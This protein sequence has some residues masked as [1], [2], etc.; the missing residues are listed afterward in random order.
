M[1]EMLSEVPPFAETKV[2]DQLSFDDL[3]RDQ[4]KFITY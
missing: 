4:E 3:E 1:L 2:C